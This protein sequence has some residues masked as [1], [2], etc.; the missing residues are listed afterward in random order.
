MTEFYFQRT[1]GGALFTK[2]MKI[3]LP[4][5]GGMT[6]TLSQLLNEICSVV[7]G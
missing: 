6:S 7:V 4:I 3:Y 2:L 5:Y 1:K